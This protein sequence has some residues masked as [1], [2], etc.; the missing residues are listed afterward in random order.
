MHYPDLPAL[1]ADRRQHLAKGP[2]ALILIE[3]A[4]EVASTIAHHKTLGFAQIIAFCPAD[5][6]L[7]ALDDTVHRVDYDVIGADAPERIVNAVIKAAP[8]AWIYFSFNAEYLYFPFCEDRSIADLTNFAMEERRN[9]I[10]CYVID[11]Y[12]SN[13]NEAPN[14]VARDAAWLDQAGYYALARHDA[15]GARP[16]RQ[17]DVYGGLR[18]RF[19]EHVPWDRRRIDRPALFR[20]YPG[21]EMGTDRL[22]NDPEYNT[23]ACP[24]HHSPTAAVCSFRTAKA[25]RHNPGSRDAIDSFVWPGSAP[26]TWHSSQLLDLGMME[27]GQWF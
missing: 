22:F 23:Y 13:L 4:I 18:W 10:L 15:T 19:E 21:L 5:M 27:P 24:W 16:E 1:F 26:F 12:A 20:A 2:I 17:V 25:L 11:L 9:S 6:T 7:P 3:D 8:G 14:G